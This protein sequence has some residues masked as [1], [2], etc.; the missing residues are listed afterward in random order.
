M[1]ILPTISSLGRSIATVIA[2]R[3]LHD[4][5]EI[6][7]LIISMAVSLVI[8]QTIPEK[9]SLFAIRQRMRRIILY[10][11]GV[12]ALLVVVA[13]FSSD[14]RVSRLGVIAGGLIATGLC[15]SLLRYHQ[16]T[17]SVSPGP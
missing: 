9:S 13:Q 3:F 1:T 12:V 2:I 17:D 15:I 14:L 7:A 5:S 8:C 11:S 10:N 4:A 16:P 6:T